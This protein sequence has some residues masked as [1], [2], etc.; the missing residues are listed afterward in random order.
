M[1]LQL[2]LQCE[3]TKH[4]VG[5][6][7]VGRALGHDD[8]GGAAVAARHGCTEQHKESHPAGKPDNGFIESRHRARLS[9]P[10]I[11]DQFEQHG[12]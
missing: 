4:L 12:N 8:E 6:L 9:T 3:Q 11:L 7:R 10:T 2:V 5:L 1:I